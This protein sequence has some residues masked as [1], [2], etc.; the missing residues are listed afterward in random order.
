MVWVTSTLDDFT[1][2]Y[3]EPIRTVGLE[4]FWPLVII[5]LVI[6]SIKH[7]LSGGLTLFLIQ[8]VP[9]ALVAANLLKY[10]YDPMPLIGVSVH[11]SFSVVARDIANI[12]DTQRMDVLFS[13]IGGILAGIQKPNMGDF[14]MLPIYFMVE[15]DMWLIEA[16]LFG[17]TAFGFVALGIGSL[18]GPL[19]IPWMIVPKL[20]HYFWNWVEYMV[21][22]AFYRVVAAALVFV[23]STFL[24]KFIDST[25]A[26]NF[27]LAQFAV[28]MPRIIVVTIAALWLCLR[29]QGLLA[30]LFKGG[31]SAGVAPR[32]AGIG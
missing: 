21:Q 20:S 10:Y 27:S 32:I 22:Y 24:T 1:T 2:Q 4:I 16:A 8:F 14:V 15:M 6:Y 7:G 3:G 17:L 23:I 11:S 25:I 29:M 13:R 30:D 26:G 12:I 19:F 9:M 5:I 28:L 18:L 31:S